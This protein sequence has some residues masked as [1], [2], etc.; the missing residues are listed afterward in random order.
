MPPS[1]QRRR[2]TI[3]VV[4]DSA[5][6]VMRDSIMICGIPDAAYRGRLAKAAAA[7]QFVP[8]GSGAI[9]QGSPALLIYDF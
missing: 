9:R 4:V 6:N 8:R 2:A 3:R 7:L 5:G 1:V